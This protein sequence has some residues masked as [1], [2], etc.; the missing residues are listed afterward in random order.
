MSG[1]RCTLAVI[2][3][4]LH[5]VNGSG[6]E[7]DN[8]IPTD[9]AMRDTTICITILFLKAF[10]TLII[11]GGK[12]GDA[13]AR[14]PEDA[15]LGMGKQN[16]TPGAAS[17]D[18]RDAAAQEANLRWQR[19]V[20]NNNENEP[21]GAVVALSALMTAKSARAH[22]ALIYL[23][24]V[25]RILHTIAYSNKLQPWRSLTWFGGALSVMGLAL[26]GLIGALDGY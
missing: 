16:F 19:I 21:L 12:K 1:L 24:V 15:K 17:D 23:F 4:L 6:G 10:A 14:P 25:F 2:M 18:Q 26:N 5:R 3:L 13:G 20:A 22:S 9:R 11:Q 7:D 8:G